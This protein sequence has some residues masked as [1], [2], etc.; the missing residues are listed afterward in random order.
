MSSADLAPVLRDEL[1][2]QLKNLAN[3]YFDCCEFAFDVIPSDHLKDYHRACHESM[4]QAMRSAVG[5]MFRMP[6]IKA[7]LAEV[8]QERKEALRASKRSGQG[9]GAASS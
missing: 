7:I 6:A 9:A 5:P 1:S 4:V 2:D 8:K 3:A